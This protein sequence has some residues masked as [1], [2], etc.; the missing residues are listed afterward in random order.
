MKGNE[1]LETAE[2]ILDMVRSGVL[3]YVF[4][5]AVRLMKEKKQV[6]NVAFFALAVVSLFLSEIY[7]LVYDTMYV[8]TRMPF[9][10]NEVG[11]WAM[12]LL[13]GASLNVTPQLSFREA[14]TEVLGCIL[15][16]GANTALWIGWSGEWLQDILTGLCYGYFLCMLLLRSKREEALSTR[17]EA[18]LAITA[19]VLVAGQTTTFFVPEH[20]RRVVDLCC[21]VFMFAVAAILLGIAIRSLE[22]KLEPSRVLCLSFIAFSWVVA[23]MY[24]SSGVWFLVAMA[25]SAYCFPLMLRALKREVDA[26]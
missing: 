18:C 22:K 5:S 8:N 24:M 13:F 23:A 26:I 15:F 16:A 12:F 10:A 25:L 19:F 14:R 4:L 21:Y 1:T 3:L 6:T 11:E 9:A 2:I 7:W 17:G 20:I